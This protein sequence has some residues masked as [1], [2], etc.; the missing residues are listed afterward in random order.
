MAAQ[1]T[2]VVAAPSSTA[3]F[4]RHHFDIAV[5]I[6]GTLVT[7]RFWSVVFGVDNRVFM[8]ILALLSLCEIVKRMVVA[9]RGNERPQLFCAERRF[10]LIS[11]IALATTPW[12]ITIPLNAASPLAALPAAFALAESL[13]PFAGVIVIAVAAYRLVWGGARKPAR[14]L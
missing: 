14:V 3:W 1:G 8:T 7:L 12:P 5:L 9:R 4:R 11:A 13:R 2:D 6:L 10:D